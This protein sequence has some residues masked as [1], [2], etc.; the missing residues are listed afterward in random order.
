VPADAV[1]V[2]VPDRRIVSAADAAVAGELGPAGDLMCRT[3]HRASW[4]L[5]SQA[6]EHLADRAVVAPGW[7]DAWHD[8]APEDRDV[9]LLRAAAAVRQA[10]EVRS[11]RDADQV[12]RD[13][14]AAF[15]SLLDDAHPLIGAAIEANPGDPVPWE[16]A[17]AQARGMQRPPEVIESCLRSMTTADPAHVPGLHQALLY[18]APRWSG[19]E[20][21]LL[22]LADELTP[23]EHEAGSAASLVPLIAVLEL[24]LEGETRTWSTTPPA[25]ALEAASRAE[26]W[27][28]SAGRG[29]DLECWARSALVWL[30]FVLR[31]VE[32]SYRHLQ[33]LGPRI[34]SYPW[35]YFEDPDAAFRQVRES[36]VVLVAGERR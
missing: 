17:L 25:R 7:L 8:S 21:A 32:D 11:A 10:W 6:V 9:A 13:Q 12:A 22:S 1:V 33:A 5:R 27:L 29:H 31:R 30:Y 18:V 28:E 19:S 24:K 15:F 20:D 34:E 4:T 16:W 35:R 2:G 36:V 23:Q 3:R 14:F 26:A